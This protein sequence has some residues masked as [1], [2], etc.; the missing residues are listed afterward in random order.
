MESVMKLSNDMIDFIF[1]L[2]TKQSVDHGVVWTH[3]FPQSLDSVKFYKGVPGQ[4]CYVT[5]ERTLVG[6]YR[7]EYWRLSL[8]ICL[9]IQIDQILL[10]ITSTMI[11]SWVVN[12]SD[13]CLELLAQILDRTGQVTQHNSCHIISHDKHVCKR[14]DSWQTFRKLRKQ[15]HFANDWA[16][17]RQWSS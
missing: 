9:Y 1:E 14:H 3:S 10:V 7:L 15:G 11:P 6:R 13:N 5:D 2:W 4:T 12:L 17:Y 16:C 8:L